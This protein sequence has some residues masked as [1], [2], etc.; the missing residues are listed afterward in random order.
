MYFVQRNISHTSIKLYTIKFL[1]GFGGLSF[2]CL[3]THSQQW[4]KVGFGGWEKNLKI[5]QFMTFQNLELRALKPLVGY[6]CYANE[7]GQAGPLRGR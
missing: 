2:H 1:S 7:V 5:L 3:K 6:L 4:P